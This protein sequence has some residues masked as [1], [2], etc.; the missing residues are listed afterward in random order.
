[1]GHKTL[2]YAESHTLSY[3]PWC[4]FGVF[5]VNFEHASH[6]VFLLLSLNMQLPA[7]SI[8]IIFVSYLQTKLKINF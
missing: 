7:G 3:F 2:A 5:I 8:M 1:M 6:L 4:R